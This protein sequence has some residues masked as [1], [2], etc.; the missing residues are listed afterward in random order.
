MNKVILLTSLLG[1]LALTGCDKVNI[2]GLEK[3]SEEP[4]VIVTEPVPED[5][6]T[7]QTADPQ[8][9]EVPVAEPTSEKVVVV[10]VDDTKEVI[11][12]ETTVL[13]ASK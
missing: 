11:V 1:V 5:S 13:K 10:P 2:P 4:V 9:L 7:E 3:A 6:S 8:D 12:E